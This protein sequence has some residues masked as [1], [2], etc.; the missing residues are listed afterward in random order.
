[1]D[2]CPSGTFIEWSGE[3]CVTDCAKKVFYVYERNDKS[4]N[5][6]L[7][8]GNRCERPVQEIVMIGG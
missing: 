5:R 6:C 1:M 4:F 2:E 8:P 7:N 3:M